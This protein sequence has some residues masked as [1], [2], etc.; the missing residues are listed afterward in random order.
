MYEI[1][2]INELP[3]VSNVMQRAQGLALLDAIVMPDW[4]F[5]YFSFNC[6]WN[7]SESELMASMRDGSGSEF[8]IL[9]SPKGAIGKILDANSD[10]NVYKFLEK[11]PNEFASFK[12]EDAF[13]LEDA[14][15]Y[16]WRSADDP[17]WSAIPPNGQYSR[18]LSFFVGG[19]EVYHDWAESYYE[20]AIDLKTLKEVFESLQVS[21]E[22][23]H[24]LNSYLPMEDLSSDLNEILGG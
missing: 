17:V 15:C 19:I 23:L 7:V 9:F 12:M 1:D 8:F 3:S 11:I 4:N 16:F 14:T 6:T 10:E 24:L 13:N 5:R 20:R 18:Y 2:N 21:E 22:N